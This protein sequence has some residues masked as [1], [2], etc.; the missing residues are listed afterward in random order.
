[1]IAD[2]VAVLILTGTFGFLTGRLGGRS[3]AETRKDFRRYTDTDMCRA[4]SNAYTCVFMREAGR[5]HEAAGP[6][7]AVMATVPDRSWP[8]TGANP[9]RTGVT[10]V[11]AYGRLS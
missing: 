8:G 6:F 1:M 4:L 7:R 3:N 10:R 9:V 11:T 2:P 5:R